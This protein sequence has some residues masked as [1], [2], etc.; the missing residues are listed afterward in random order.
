MSQEYHFG[1]LCYKPIMVLGLGSSLEA[2]SFWCYPDPRIFGR[3]KG[4][5]IILKA[6]C[7]SILKKG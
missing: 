5:E 2:G 7:G 6:F 1:K 3:L 4:R